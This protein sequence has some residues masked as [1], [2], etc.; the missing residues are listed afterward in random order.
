MAKAHAGIAG[1]TWGMSRGG[2]PR[3]IQRA[4]EPPGSVT[5]DSGP[6]AKMRAMGQHPSRRIRRC[7]AN[8]MLATEV[9][10]RFS[11]SVL[12][13]LQGPWWGLGAGLPI[14]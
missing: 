7:L 10:A 14:T 8:G 2:P 13:P 4:G 5:G 6:Q 12:P 3:K 9:E 11:A 1:P